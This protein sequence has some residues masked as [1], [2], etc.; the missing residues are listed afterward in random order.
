MIEIVDVKKVQ[1]KGDFTKSIYQQK[2]VSLIIFEKINI[3]TITS[4]CLSSCFQRKFQ[5]TVCQRNTQTGKNIYKCFN[6]INIGINVSKRAEKIYRRTTICYL[7]EQE[8][9]P[10]GIKVKDHCHLAGKW[11]VGARQFCNINVREG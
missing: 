10:I 9:E 3:R 7:S 5:W 6:E 8:I 1:Q 4:V 2:A 11:R